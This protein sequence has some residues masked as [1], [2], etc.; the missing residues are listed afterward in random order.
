MGKYSDKRPTA[1]CDSECLPNYWSIE[2]H[3]VDTG[4]TRLFEQCEDHGLVLDRTA[5]AT[6][7]RKWRI[8]TFNGR[9]YDIPMILLAMRGASNTELK[10]ASDEIIQTNLREW[11]FRD[12]YDLMI[13]DFFDHIDLFEVTPSAATVVALKGLAGRLHSKRMMEMPIKHDTRVTMAQIVQMRK[14][15]GT[16]T[17]VTKEL[18]H[19]LK[20]QLE[21][22]AF[23]SDQ[24][25]I[26]LRSKSDAQLAEAVI[27]QKVEAMAG[28]RI[29]KP[30]IE[31]GFFKYV[32]P[33]YIQFQ[34]PQMQAVLD[35]VLRANFRI[36]PDGYVAVETLKE[37][38]VDIGG[39]T[40]QMGN[41]GLHSQEK[42]ISHYSG[43]GK[44]LRDRDVTGYYPNLI[45]ASGRY[46]KNMGQH[47]QTVFRDIVRTRAAAKVKSAAL[48]KA[49]DKG[50]AA[51]Q[52]AIAESMKIMTNGTFGKTGS[53]FSPLYSPELM[54]YTTV[55]GQLSILMLIEQ[56]TLRG[57]EVV[58]ANTDGFVTLVP[59]DEYLDFKMMLFD[60][61][62]ESGLGTEETVYRSLHSKDVNN[63]FA[64]AE[65]PTE[66]DGIKVKR[67]G[68]YTESGRG[69]KAA[70]GLKKN[71]NMDICNDAVMEFLKHG[72]RIES[73]IRECQDI[74]KF[75]VV[76]R[77]AEGGGAWKNG[78]FIAKWIRY[79]YGDDTPGPILNG[80]G[81][82]VGSSE[83]A[84]LCLE[85][86]DELPGNID[87]A[88]YER[89]AYAIL[90]DIGVPVND[91]DHMGRTGY[92]L[93]RLPDQKT[94]HTINYGTGVALCGVRKKSLREP[95]L[96]VDALP[97]GHKHCK[98][99]R[100]DDEI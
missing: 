7:F 16:D 47:F 99:C 63:Y 81:G 48:K 75:V 77:V 33:T 44:T 19:E 3:C 76:G 89:E 36:K 2:F 71:P 98:K 46:P 84:C 13:P 21:L 57:W 32:A 29:Y 85:L 27:K 38:V 12:K 94:F 25:G 90:H 35:K 14:Y 26:D 69:V 41:G 45:I 24:H 39:H 83:G 8:V 62:C 17:V 67:K 11:E 1:T 18:Y 40:Y 4:R 28:R 97:D 5:I 68:E 80:S 58:S 30:D 43:D 50:G 100:E 78:E 61:E 66:K 9:H 93:A 73:T 6:M 59:D 22:R 53:P 70:Y 74:R 34:T 15:L 10:H 64:L 20:D 49:G 52:A 79:Y 42:S 37:I 31:R 92:G 60:W 86:P 91:P 56:C 72:T 88:R 96:E 23:M 82:R 87:Y 54:I 95:W 65:D 51:V 55:T